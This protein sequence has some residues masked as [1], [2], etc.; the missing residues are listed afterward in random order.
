MNIVGGRVTK[1]TAQKMAENVVQ[2]SLNINLIVKGMELKSRQ[3]VVKYSYGIDYKEKQAYMEIE[4]E[5][6]LQDSEKAMRE[7]EEKYKKSKNIDP[8]LAEQILNSA[9]YTGMAIGS[10]LAFAVGVPAPI[11]VQKFKVDNK[12]SAG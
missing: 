7:T 9:T 6:Y 1:T 3:L 12:P 10:L 5:L 2:T 4:G 8:S 11:T